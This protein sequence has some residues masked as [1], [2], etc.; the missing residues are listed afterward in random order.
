MNHLGRRRRR[1]SLGTHRFQRAVMGKD[2]LIGIRHDRGLVRHERS[3]L[4]DSIWDLLVRCLAGAPFLFGE[5]SVFVGAESLYDQFG[6][7]GAPPVF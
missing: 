3:D 1:K 4:V 7:K 2:V 5:G 6:I